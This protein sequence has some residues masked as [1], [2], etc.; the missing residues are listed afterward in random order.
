[1]K[2]V[3]VM[4]SSFQV[5]RNRSL[6]WSAHSWGRDPALLGRPLDLQPVLVGAGEEHDVV[7]PEA[8]PPGEDVGD[9]RRVRVPD[10]GHVVHVV[11]RRRH[12]EG[13]RPPGLRYRRFRA[14]VR[15]SRAMVGEITVSSG[16]SRKVD[17]LGR[18]VLPAELRK[19][20]EINEGDLSRSRSTT[21][22]ASC[23]RRSRTAASSAGPRDRAPSCASSSTSSSASRASRGS[24][25]P[26]G[27]P[28]A[29]R[30]AASARRARP[31]SPPPR[32]V[33]TAHGR[34]RR[35]LRPRALPRS[36]GVVSGGSPSTTMTCSP[37][38]SRCCASAARGPSGTV[39]H[40]FVQLGDLARDAHGAVVAAHGREIRKRR[41]DAARRLEEHHGARLGRDRVD[42]LAGGPCPCGAGSLRTRSG[43]RRSP[44]A[45]AR[46]ARHSAREPPPPGRR[47]PGRRARSRAPGSL[48][49]GMPASVAYAT[50][51]PGAHLVDD[52]RGF[53]LLVV[54][55]HRAQA[56]LC[57]D[58]CVRQQLAGPPG[59]LARDHVRA[60]QRLDDPRATGRRGCR[61]G[62]PIRTRGTR[63]SL[64]DLDLVPD[65]QT[66]RSNAPASAS[67]TSRDRHTRGE[68]R[69]GF[70]VEIRT[71]RPSAS[72]KATSM[73]NRMPDGVHL[74]ALAE[75]ECAGE[76]RPGRAARG[77]ARGACSPL[78]PLRAP[79]RHVPATLRATSGCVGRC[80]LEQVAVVEGWPESAT[81]TSRGVP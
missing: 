16:V 46:R 15:P 68:M 81:P 74:A 8:A 66:P 37:R 75:Q 47:L 48:T 1:M 78:R 10:V 51:E 49:P 24:P 4:S 42:P 7:A 73:A 53:A 30:H 40:L 38:G 32:R 29:R 5:S 45:R 22:G 6:V 12:E 43:R 19:Q 28:P 27:E 55:V 35:A 34:A 60:A 31:R 39:Q 25:V 44:T 54:R 58:P 21:T 2:S 77:S 72:Q 61:S 41:G 17:R 36:P 59:V 64:L 50:V 62:V 79:R 76:A 69:Q 14:T 52:P 57:R 18:V 26:K 33:P 63:R 11:D 56:A 13:L 80:I 3:L 70:S 9:D 65:P 23:S 71:T 20:L 67:I